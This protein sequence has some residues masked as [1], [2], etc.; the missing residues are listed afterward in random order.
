MDIPLH[1][2][3]FLPPHLRVR[4]G[5]ISAEAIEIMASSLRE[6]GQLQP[7]LV[8]PMRDTGRRTVIFGETRMRGAQLLGWREIR[9]EEFAGDDAQIMAAQLAENLVRS[10]M[11]PVEKWRAMDRLLSSGFTAPA[12]AATLGITEREARQLQ[13]LGCL[14]PTIIEHIERGDAPNNRSLAMIASA[15]LNAQ[16]LALKSRDVKTPHGGISWH[17]LAAALTKTKIPRSRAIFDPANAGLVF[18]DDLFAP[19]DQPESY[20]TDVKL[21]L[22]LQTRALD[23]RV[24]GPPK[25]VDYVHAFDFA[26]GKRTKFAKDAEREYNADPLKAKRGRLVVWFLDREGPH[27]GEVRG[28]VY[29]LPPKKPKTEPAPAPA[30]RTLAGATPAPRDDAADAESDELDDGEGLEEAEAETDIPAPE[31]AG[32]TKAGLTMLA[33]AKTAALRAAVG[34]PMTPYQAVVSLLLL[35]TAPNVQVRGVYERDHPTGLLD[36]RAR[37]VLPDGRIDDEMSDA[38]LLMIASDLLRRC[39]RCAGPDDDQRSPGMRHDAGKVA[40]WLGHALSAAD[41]LPRLDTPAFL[42]TISGDILRQ[43]AIEH[44][45]K[46]LSKV[47]DLR[48]QLAGK[49]PDWKPAAAQ[50]GAP[51]PKPQRN[52]A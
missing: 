37:L 48:T 40:E 46:P 28:E 12:A 29:K 10:A 22:E 13:R 19:A 32:I 15:T 21:F 16:D 1:L 43:I 52:A 33:E 4:R 18:E 31:P 47:S 3:E 5:E 23:A 49:L 25:G 39:L 45:I 20:T 42:A 34:E 24:L 9:A 2:L 14:H 27:I 50:F 41:H 6:R 30:K 7:I 17:D 36:L 11:T 38:D 51:G 44:G 26:T 8:G 35:L